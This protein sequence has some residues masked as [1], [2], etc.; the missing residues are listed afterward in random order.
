[1]FPFLHRIFTGQTAEEEHYRN[2]QQ[3][4]S[5][6]KIILVTAMGGFLYGYD[7]GIINDILEMKYVYTNFPSS[8]NGFST[9]ERAI[10]VAILSLGTFFGALTAPWISDTYG[11]K[12]TIMVASGIL[13][14]IGNVLQIAAAEVALLCVGRFVSG[15][16]IGCLSASIPLFQ[17]EVS[18][19]RSRGSVVFTYQFSITC[20]L[21]VSSAISQGTRKLHNS[22]S[23]RIPVGLQFAWAVLLFV[24]MLFLPES[25][26]FYVQKNDLQKALDSLCK[27]R[28]L[29]PDDE[30][31]IEELV[32]I[33]ANYD[34]ELSYGKSTLLDCFRS[35]GGRHKQGLRM[36][37]GMGVQFFQ[38]CSGINFIFYYGVNF[39]LSTG[40]HNYYLMSFITY[41]VNVIFTIPGIM[42]IDVVGRR[43]L[44]FWGGVGMA[45][46]NFIIAICGV[47]INDSQ[48]NAIL[49]VSFA[50]VF[51][52]FFASTW[53]GST[54]ALCSDIYGISVRQKAFSLTAATNWIVNFVFAYIT[55]YLI[56]T[57]EHTAAIGSRIFFMWGS[58]NAAGAIFVFFTVYET[59]GLKLEEVDFMYAHCSNARASKKFKSTKIDFA[60]LD[61]NYNPIP[62]EHVPDSTSSNDVY[63]DKTSSENPSPQLLQPLYY[64]KQQNDLTI[65]PYNNII[66]PT[67]TS[68]TN[69]QESRRQSIL[70]Q[71]EMSSIQSSRSR[72][73]AQRTKSRASAI[74]N[75][76]Q[77]YL[78][79]IKREYSQHYQHSA[80]MIKQLS[81][82][83]NTNSSTNNNIN[84][85]YEIHPSIEDE[86]RSSFN[87]I[88]LTVNNIPTT[89]IATPYFDQPPSDSDSTD[90]SEDE[91]EADADDEQETEDR[92]SLNKHVTNKKGG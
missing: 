8:G 40:I 50:C 45:I 88:P 32:D 84:P 67:S 1:M 61:E 92:Q 64:N 53:G 63:N 25:P 33:K 19:K 71:R 3:R 23:Y 77:E 60:H 70:S 30:E 66:S 75:D 12:F 48:I 54:W 86:K 46:S 79:S 43:P 59:K 41:L 51:I 91:Q 76:Y 65:I 47:S 34:Y 80:S 9:H 15:I 7:T 74:S 44:L 13:F 62:Q 39:F 78:D 85:S 89:I 49:C 90:E 83:S 72:S 26:R 42:L 18:H 2:K 69:G 22:G 38:Q 14:N 10:I 56:D 55:P 20:G 16:S 27:L 37:T 73:T 68:S 81:Q 21:L 31:V 29:P 87:E 28:R 4:V 11:R 36:W 17:A 58:L 24:G 82:N 5:A 35:G 6:F 52:A 57:G